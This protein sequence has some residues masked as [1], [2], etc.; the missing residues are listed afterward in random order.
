MYDMLQEIV[1]AL[2]AVGTGDILIALIITAVANLM[3]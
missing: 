2:S 1:L 3:R